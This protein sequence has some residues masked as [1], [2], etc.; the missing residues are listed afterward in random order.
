MIPVICYSFYLPRSDALFSNYFEEDLLPLFRFTPVSI[1][2]SLPCVGLSV[3]AITAREFVRVHTGP[4]VADL[5]GT[6]LPFVH[7]SGEVLSTDRQ[8]V[9]VLPSTIHRCPAWQRHSHI[10]TVHALH[11]RPSHSTSWSS[12]RGTGPL[13][14]LSSVPLFGRLSRR[15]ISRE[16]YTVYCLPP[17]RGRGCRTP[18]ISL[19]RAAY[20]SGWTRT[21]ECAS[22]RKI[23]SPA[24]YMPSRSEVANVQTET[25]PPQ[26][27]LGRVR[28]SRTTTQQSPRWLQWDARNPLPKLRAPSLRRSSPPSNTPIH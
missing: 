22:C 5:S 9:Q 25:S 8:L 15:R 11:S 27:N 6:L 18:K 1:L 26:S 23:H 14:E 2:P 28:R 10:N 16:S 24:G 21:T 4:S 7:S 3:G 20:W 17:P 13:R 12:E 19:H